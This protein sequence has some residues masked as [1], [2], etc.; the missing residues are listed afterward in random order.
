MGY[1]RATAARPAGM[2]WLADSHGKA[3]HIG[4]N[5][6]S[7]LRRMCRAMPSGRW[8]S[9]ALET[10][11]ID[12]RLAR[13]AAGAARFNPRH[14]RF[15]GT[16]V[17]R[18]C[19][20]AGGRCVLQSAGCGFLGCA[21]VVGSSNSVAV[22]RATGTETF[23]GFASL[24]SRVLFSR[25]RTLPGITLL[26]VVLVALLRMAVATVLVLAGIGHD[27]SSESGPAGSAGL[28]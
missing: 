11:G 25:S 14:I 15:V 8:P 4:R 17:A 2:G 24:L 22:F 1:R 13:A 12:A 3:A 23:L 19:R 18:A 7:A 5:E 28:R 6:R 20:T 27:M 21:L 10:I 9:V 16:L 26:V